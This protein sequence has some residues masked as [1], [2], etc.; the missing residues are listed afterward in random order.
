MK[1][2]LKEREIHIKKDLEQYKKVR[3]EH[4]KAREKK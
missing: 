2:H 3:A 1:R 4:R